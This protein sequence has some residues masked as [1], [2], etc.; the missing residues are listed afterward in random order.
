MNTSRVDYTMRAISADHDGV[1]IEALEWLPPRD[2][3]DLGLPLVFIPGGTAHARTHQVHG[4]AGAMAKLGSRARRVLAVSR[5]GTG[6]SDAPAAGYLPAHF[7]GDV[8]AAIRAAGYQRFAVF[9]H[10]MGVPISLEFA[11]RYP[12]GLA[13]LVLGDAPA[14][15]IDFKADGTFASLLNERFEFLNWDA[16]LEAMTYRTTDRAADRIRFDA[17]RDRMFVE[18]PDGTVRFLIDRRGLE[19]TVEES[20][21]AATDYGPLLPRIGVPVLLIVASTGS[22]PMAPDDVSVYQRGLR[23]LTVQRLQ[24]D[25]DLGQRADPTQLRG[26][27]GAFLDRLDGHIGPPISKALPP[28]T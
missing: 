9:G 13:G 25:H 19:R 6:L 7:A 4:H 2:R 11:L 10:S 21:T 12:T 17:I 1:R 26:T 14:R 28:A 22:S 8:Q 16:A 15:Y 3:E 24:S 27:L 20:V 23:D 18:N 5:R